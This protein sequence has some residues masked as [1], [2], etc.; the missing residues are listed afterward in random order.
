MDDLKRG[1]IAVIDFGSQYTQLIARRI[2]ELG[3][4]AEVFAH[5]ASADHINLH[6]PAGYILSGG[7]SS[8]YERGA[9]E[10]PRF[11]LES[12]LPALGICYGMQLLTAAQGG[13][14]AASSEREYG[15][16]TITH[17]AQQPPL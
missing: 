9:P 5:D 3:V 13:Q 8:V 4:Y 17:E 1:G 14:V 15:P 12:A 16:A 2:R 7:P 10:L 11:L 6:R